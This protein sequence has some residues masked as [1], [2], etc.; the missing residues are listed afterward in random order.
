M[1]SS[2][3]TVPKQTK[4]VKSVLFIIIIIMAGVLVS[5]LFTLYN[6]AKAK[7]DA[8]AASISYVNLGGIQYKFADGKITLNNDA[9][10]T[11]LKTFLDKESTG[12]GC[13]DKK[14]GFEQVIAWTTDEKQVYLKYGCDAA[15]A[16][17]FATQINGGW[18]AIS[19]TNHFDIFN[20]P[21]CDYLTQNDISAKIAPVCANKVI[22]GVAT[23]KPKHIVR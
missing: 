20:I 6:K 7:N 15:V 3:P 1:P 8:D 19:P 18:K 23:G 4:I 12:S 17:M 9:S 2:T 5:S 14:P 16:P 22:G 10:V 21:D 11:S 13:D